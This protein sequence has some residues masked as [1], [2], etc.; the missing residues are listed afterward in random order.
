MPD[1]AVASRE[2]AKMICSH[3]TYMLVQKLN[4]QIQAVDKISYEKVG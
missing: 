2:I 4:K 1:T 3:N